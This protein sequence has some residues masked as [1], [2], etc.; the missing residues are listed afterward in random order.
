[1]PGRREPQVGGNG[2][3]P[4]LNNI[5]ARKNLNETAFFF[6]HLVSNDDGEVRMEFTMPEALTK[7]KFLGFAHDKELRSG[8]LTDDVVTAKDLMVQ[9]NPPRFLREGDVLEF[10]VKVSNQAATRAEGQGAALAHATPARASRSM[11]NS[12]S[13]RRTGLR[14]A[15]RR[16][17]DLLVEADCARRPRA[18]HLQGRRR[19]RRTSDGEEGFL[20]V[21]SRRCWSR[22][23]CRCRSATRARRSSTSRSCATPAESNTH[24]QPD[25]H[26]ADGLAA[27]VVRGDGAAVPD[28][29]SR[30]SAREQTFNRLY[31]NALARHIAASDPKIR[32]HLRPVEGDA[33]LDSPLEKNQDLK[34][35]L[36]EETPWVRQAVKEGQ[37]RKN[38]GILFDDNRLND[39]TANALAQKLAEMQLRRRR[40]AVVPRR[41]GQR[42]HHA[43]H[44]HRL[45]PPAAPRREDRYGRRPSNRSTRLDAWADQHVPASIL[46]HSDPDKNHL[47]PDVSRCTSTAA[48]SSS[49]DKAVA[50][51]HK[52]RGRLLARPGEEVLAAAGQPPVARRTSPSASSASATRPRPPPS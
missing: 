40:V 22:N 32:Q 39:E 16:I 23:R 41:T 25:A 6:P 15:R 52:A 49:Q 29:V 19:Q 28:G 3:G 20:P 48:V 27:G 36:L 34:S 35:V 44:H 18:D 26:G 24:P 43:L 47:Q 17:E 38:V 10:T 37:A 31:A 4:D 8:F 2:P 21:L 46:Q 1:M 13:P 50:N 9:P 30:T 14:P 45:R 7:W 42:L 11:R 5:S 33:G 12:A 51:E